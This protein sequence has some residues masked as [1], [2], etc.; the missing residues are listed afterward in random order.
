MELK[1]KR[2]EGPHF[3]ADVE[4]LKRLLA[5]S[6]TER[7][8]LGGQLFMCS[9]DTLQALDGFLEQPARA[10]SRAA[11]FS[12]TKSAKLRV[13]IDKEALAM[14][15]R[16]RVR[17][18]FAVDA[19][20][21]Y[22]LRLKGEEVLL[23]SAIEAT[24]STLLTAMHLRKG[25]L[26]SF[27]E[28]VLAA[29]TSHTYEA[30][31]HVLLERLRMQHTG[32]VFHWCGPLNAP[33]SQACI[34]APAALWAAAPPQA[35]TVSGKPGWW[36]R[37]GLSVALSVAAGVGYAGALWVPYTDYAAAAEELAAESARLQGDFSFASER[38]ALL[39]AR[40]TFLNSTQSNPKPLSGMEAAVLAIS[41]FPDV[42]IKEA[43]LYWPRGKTATSSGA[44][45]E[46]Y[47]FEFLLEV[48]AVPGTT[49]LDQSVPLVRG[50]SQRMGTS[51][52]L[53]TIDGMR[54]VNSPQGKGALRHYRIQG[55][56]SNAS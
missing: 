1:V 21:R 17:P 45:R 3:A 18:V 55:D 20:L 22:G 43:Q 37:Y 13:A 28:F 48:P 4:Q 49:A 12:R 54:E 9:L 46:A 34:T 2:K 47:D 14:V 6:P 31:V 38:L 11:V 52:R 51:L 50:L 24:Y 7:V 23:L 30:D 53:S 27:E 32:A 42:R 15:A 44:T 19:L 10:T 25:E 39:Q 8:V 40:Q 16:A 36:R 56:F 5:K 26:V 35:L 33:R 41:A 29:P